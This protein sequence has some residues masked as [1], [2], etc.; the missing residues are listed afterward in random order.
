MAG[1]P[2][3]CESFAIASVTI[4][5]EAE[6][7]LVN[8]TSIAKLDLQQLYD[9]AKFNGLSMEQFEESVNVLEN[10]FSD[11]SFLV[12]KVAVSN[13]AL[14][15]DVDQDSIFNALLAETYVG[16]LNCISIQLAQLS[17]QIFNLDNEFQEKRVEL[18]KSY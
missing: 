6:S 18:L 5:Q 1:G 10:Q 12:I 2:A 15:I 3:D 13:L 4:I 17:A 16:R 9:D 7:N 14:A 8:V 11:N